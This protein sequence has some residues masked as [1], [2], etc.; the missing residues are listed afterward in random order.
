[1]N[2][3]HSVNYTFQNMPRDQLSPR[4]ASGQAKA[5]RV[6]FP[7]SSLGRQQQRCFRASQCLPSPR[8]TKSI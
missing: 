2:S 1:M 4:G 7:G 6:Q 3:Y 8:N 5:R